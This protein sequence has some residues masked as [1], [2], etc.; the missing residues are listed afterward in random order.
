M[1]EDIKIR[2][3]KIFYSEENENENFIPLFKE[4]SK[5]EILKLYQE[6]FNSNNSELIL[7]IYNF[8]YEIMLK[9]YDIAIILIKS[10]S[11][12]IE[13]NISIIELLIESYLKFPN[14]ENLKDKI[15][16]ILHFFI[17]NFSIDT[18]HYFY[19]FKSITNNDKN[20]SKE[21]FNNYLDILKV[22]YPKIEKEKET[23]P[24]NHEK[25]FFFII[26]M[27]VV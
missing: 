17:D 20:P 12:I 16:E 15:Y 4:N 10:E 24:I 22:F 2:F 26:Y 27:K 11:L 19:L 6:I 3:K 7:K 14:N 13:K 25:Y 5:D 1:D 21:T 23:N 18:K 8:L 9:C